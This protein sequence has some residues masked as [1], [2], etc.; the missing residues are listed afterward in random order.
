V[1]AEYLPGGLSDPDATRPPTG[2][3]LN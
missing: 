1:L 2:P 3:D